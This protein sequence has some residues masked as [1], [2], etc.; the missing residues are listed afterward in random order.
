MS[1]WCRLNARGD[2]GPRIVALCQP[3]GPVLR[4]ATHDPK[5]DPNG[6]IDAREKRS[7]LITAIYY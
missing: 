6:Y 3:L 5:V 4:Y 7:I 2:V 1:Y